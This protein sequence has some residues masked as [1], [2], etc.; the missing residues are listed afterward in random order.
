MKFK[1]HL[2]RS[3]AALLLLVG[4]LRAQSTAVARQLA[5]TPGKEITLQ[6]DPAQCGTEITLSSTLHTVEGTFSFKRG[7]IHYE[8]VSGK[9]SGEIVFDA[10]SGKTGNG[11]RDRRMHREIMESSRFAE[12]T[13]H[14]DH[15]DGVLASSGKSALKIH[16]RFG[17]RGVEHEV[18]LPVEFT[19]AGNAWTATSSFQ[20]PYVEWGMKDPSMLFLRVSKTVEVKFRAAGTTQ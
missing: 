3:I 11:S 10:M 12:I 7:T 1:S 15:A 8:P 6:F 20:V 2:W 14:P 16:G 5:A 18:T 19:L 9:A 13:F 17:I 4:P